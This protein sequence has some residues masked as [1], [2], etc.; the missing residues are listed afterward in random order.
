[1]IFS[2]NSLLVKTLLSIPF[3]L[4]KVQSLVYTIEVG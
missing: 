3:V 2:V 4:H 1:M